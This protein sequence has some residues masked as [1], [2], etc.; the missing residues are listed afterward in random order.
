MSFELEAGRDARP[1]RRVGLRQVG[2][3][4]R[5][6]RARADAR[7]ASSRRA[8]VRFEGRDLL[9]L[10]P[11]ELRRVRGKEISD[12]LPGPDD[13]RSIRCSRSGG[14][15]P[16]CSRSTAVT[17]RPR[18]AQGL[19][20]GPRRRRRSRSPRHAARP[21]PARALGRHAPARDD[22]DGAPLQAEAAAR[23]RADDRARRHDPGADPRADEGPAAAAR[24]GDRPRHPRP[25]RR[26]GDGRPRARHVRGAARRDR[27][28]GRRSSGRRATPTRAGMLASVPDARRRPRP[29]SSPRSP[30][31]RPT[32][33]A[34][35]AAARSQPRCAL[36][37]SSSAWPAPLPLEQVDPDVSR[38]PSACAACFE[39]PREVE[40]EGA[41]GDLVSRALLEVDGLVKH[42]PV[43]GAA[44][45]SCAR[46]RRH[47][48]RAR[49][50]RV[51]G[52]R[53]RV[54]LRQV[55][56]LRARSSDCTPHLGL[57][58]LRRRRA[59][60]AL[61]AQRARNRTGGAMQ[62]IFQDP[63]ASLDPRQ[64]VSLDP[65]EE[66]MRIHGD[67]QSRASASCARCSCSTP[68]ASTRVTSTATRTS[69]PAA[70]ASASAS[71]ARSRSSRTSSSAT[72]P[73]QRPRRVDPG[74][75][76][77]L[78]ARS[79]KSASDLAYLFIAHD[80][81]VV[82]HICR[83]IAVMYLGRI[84][85]TADREDLFERPEH[86]YT[87]SLLSAVPHPD[88]SVERSRTRIVLEGDVPSPDDPPSGCAFHPRCPERERVPGDRCARE[89]PP[90]LPAG[91]GLHTRACHLEGQRAGE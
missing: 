71:R 38:T 60:D 30:A 78:A 4:P 50:R 17:S 31:R 18:G 84:V 59:H 19:R 45:S 23:R 64:T 8:R 5:D 44:P 43:E 61:A 10:P 63:Y 62:M 9:T 87:R 2:D 54:G 35:P 58:H 49:A 6:P 85:E 1:R 68:S 39:V 75:D 70:S 91:P 90:L 3:E 55:D 47:L 42:F 76:H 72:S 79:C 27:A 46:D 52:S 40:P 81:A 36:A 57:G 24:H 48:V 20:G 53:R 34:F 83:R 29:P 28:D 13:V 32:S 11:A 56:T 25:R 33:R 86:P 12:D 26:R 65:G 21:V 22:R 37:R 73:C 51:A 67:R 41:G 15:S 80:L 77:Q 66:P 89:V 69:S 14:S 74:A 88:P 7:P 82:R 16:R